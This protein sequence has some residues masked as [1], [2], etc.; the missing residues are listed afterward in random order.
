MDFNRHPVIYVDSKQRIKIKD[1]QAK[2]SK[3]P[4]LVVHT[5]E[6]N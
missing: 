5:K 2:I 3:T 6:G 1:P 4:H